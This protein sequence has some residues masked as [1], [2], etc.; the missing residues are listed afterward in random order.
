VENEFLLQSIDFLSGHYLPKIEQC[1]AALSEEDF[2]WRPNP[3]SNSVGNLILH[4]SGNVR[5][6]IVSGIGGKPDTRIRQEEFDATGGMKKDEVI[7]RLR[8]TVNEACDVLKSMNPDRLSE[9]EMI[10]GKEV[11]LLYAVYHVVEH[12]SMHTGQIIQITKD[13]VGRDLKFYGFEKGK[14]VENWRG[15]SGKDREH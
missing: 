10:Q 7:G 6:W 12:F 14:P 9:S 4:L 3:D 15:G 2:W 13:R 5:Q 1:V 8:E 11:P